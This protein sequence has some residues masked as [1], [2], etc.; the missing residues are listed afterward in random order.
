MPW[1]SLTSLWMTAGLMVVCVV[2]VLG[3]GA[4]SALGDE[5]EP[6][7]GVIGVFNPTDL[8]P[9]GSGTLVLHV[10]NIG[11]KQSESPGPTLVDELPAG[12]EGVEGSEPGGCSGT[13]TVTCELGEVAPAPEGDLLEIPVRVLPGASNASGAVDRVSVSGG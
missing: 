7:W 9:G 1:R 11:G 3:L 6:G 10:Y 4:V 2:C 8:A 12:V 13:R 5:A